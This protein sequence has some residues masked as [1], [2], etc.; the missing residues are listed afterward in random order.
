MLLCAVYDGGGS[1]DHALPP[2]IGPFGAMPLSAPVG[3]TL[4]APGQFPPRTPRLANPGEDAPQIYVPDS[5]FEDATRAHYTAPPDK[6]LPAAP[7]PHMHRGEEMSA[8]PPS[9]RVSH[10][11]RADESAAPL[12][13]VA[14]QQH[15]LRPHAHDRRA[16]SLAPSQDISGPPTRDPSPQR[17]SSLHTSWTLN[18]FDPSPLRPPPVHNWPPP[19]DPYFNVNASAVRTNTF[20]SPAPR[21]LDPDVVWDSPYLKYVLC[22]CEYAYMCV[23][24]S[25]YLRACMYI[26]MYQCVYM[27]V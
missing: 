10:L 20:A 21:L 1:S 8:M 22:M 9:Q 23:F 12:A 5:E 18:N 25:S 17:P 7:V 2:M 16:A 26:S 27:Y 4:A 24:V 6:M 14:S 15:M 19:R 13:L 3:N 11:Y